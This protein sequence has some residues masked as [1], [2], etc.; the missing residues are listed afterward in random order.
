MKIIAVFLLIFAVACAQSTI[1]ATETTPVQAAPLEVQTTSGEEFSLAKNVEEG[2][3]TVVYF[4]ASW[5]PKCAQ[6]WESLNE[7]Y[8]K[9]E[10]DVE[11]IAVSIDPTDTQDVLAEL[12]VEK[13]F[14][15]KTTPGNPQ[16][17]TD[18]NVAEQTTKFAI[19]AQG[20]IVNK[21]VGVLST[22]E[23]DEFFQSAQ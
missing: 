3:P 4:M 19:D 10:D 7:V 13:G 21:H 8:P 12:A 17:A 23:W 5:C 9:Y 6:N 11:F 14:V 2:K 1:T 22:Q 20:N 15:F 16:L 18:Y